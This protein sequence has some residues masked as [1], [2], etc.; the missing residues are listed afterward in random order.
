MR[1]EFQAGRRKA[2]VV[3]L[4]VRIGWVLVLVFM[5]WVTTPSIKPEKVNVKELRGEAKYQA[6][7][8]LARQ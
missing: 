7:E 3:S 2:A 4:A 6:L 1:A 8:Q 5:A